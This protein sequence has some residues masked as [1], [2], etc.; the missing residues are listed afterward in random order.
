MRIALVWLTL[1]MA[2]CSATTTATPQG[3]SAADFFDRQSRACDDM[4]RALPAYA[5]LQG[6]YPPIGEAPPM[7]IQALTTRPS[8]ADK[9]A[10]IELYDKGLSPCRATDMENLAGIHPAYVPYAVRAYAEQDEAYRALLDGTS[11]WGQY[12]QVVAR[13][14]DRALAETQE[15]NAR[16]AADARAQRAAAAQY[17]QAATAAFLNWNVQQRALAQQQQLIN[18]AYQPRI[19]TCGYIGAN[20]NCTTF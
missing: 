17:R 14:R 1:L 9:L 2:G 3:E 19:T 18:R 10:L 8:A 12:A 5:A 11:T 16:V 13:V 15:I 6:K 7:A 4:I 20:L